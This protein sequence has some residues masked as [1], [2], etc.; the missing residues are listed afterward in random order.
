M[1][2]IRISLVTLAAATALLATTASAGASDG[3]AESRLVARSVTSALAAPTGY[4]GWATPTTRS[5][6]G[7]R[8]G[9][10]TGGR[11]APNNSIA[12]GNPNCANIVGGYYCLVN[13]YW[14]LPNWWTTVFHVFSSNGTFAGR[15]TCY[16]GNS[17]YG[18]TYCY[19]G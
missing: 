19:P 14:T 13:Q 1:L 9:P 6:E 15:M 8:T 10:R 2:G 12:I 7:G 11:M 18:A 3:S 16:T 17:G 5:R 4:R